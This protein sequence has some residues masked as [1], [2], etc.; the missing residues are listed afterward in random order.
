MSNGEVIDAGIV[1]SYIPKKGID[2]FTDGD[3]EEIIQSVIENVE[4][5]YT[6][7]II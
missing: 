2:Y 5:S 6:L 1:P 7:E 4:D 3:K